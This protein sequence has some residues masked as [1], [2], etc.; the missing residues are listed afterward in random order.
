MTIVAKPPLRRTPRHDDITVFLGGSIDMGNAVDWQAE[1]TEFLDG[2]VDI[3]FNP[4]RNDWDSS[5]EQTIEHPEFNAQVNW[6][7]DNIE[8]ADIVVMYITKESSAPISMME[9][10]LL[11]ANYDDARKLIVYCPKGFYRKGNVDIICE[12]SG[13]FVSETVEEFRQELSNKVQQ[14]SNMHEAMADAV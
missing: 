2:T 6:E 5:W 1:T 9:L 3:I 14:L 4:R 13:V 11:C 10:G 7:L 8:L 12:R